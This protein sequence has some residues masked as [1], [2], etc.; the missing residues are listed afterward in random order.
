MH[1][2]TVTNS[3]GSALIERHPV[4][5]ISTMLRGSADQRGEHRKTYE[6]AAFDV[7]AFLADEIKS[8]LVPAPDS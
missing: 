5:L 7:E 4:S 3:S 8:T 1:R 6:P 2:Q